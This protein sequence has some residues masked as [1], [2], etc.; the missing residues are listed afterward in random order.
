MIMSLLFIMMFVGSLISGLTNV[1]LT[2]RI[3]F[4]LVT[5]L[6]A[7]AT[8]VAYLIAGTGPPYPLFLIGYI[9]NGF[10]MGIQ[11]AQVNNLVTRLPNADMKMSIVQAC[12]SL[13]GTVAP[14]I[15]T[16]FAQHVHA[17]YRYFFVAMAVALITVVMMFAAFEGKTEEQLTE[18]LVP[19]K[20]ANEKEEVEMAEHSSPRG[21]DIAV[22]GE[23]E[24]P[25]PPVVANEAAPLPPADAE[26]LYHPDSSGTKMLRIFS[27]PSVYALIGWAFLYVGVE[28][29]LSGWLT[30]FLIKE[31][32]GSAASGYAVTGFWGG[33]SV[34]RIVLIPVTKKI[35]YQFSIYL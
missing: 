27:T 18:G 15:S 28:V 13:G 23:K 2:D 11:D 6:A 7:F 34:G 31:R 21:G 16:A 4:G 32:G 20:D 24:G 25:S 10:G 14:F 17:A 1:W 30:T 26:I 3:G 35:G 8:A 12:F 9:F 5:P 22:H 19:N 33:M 29:S